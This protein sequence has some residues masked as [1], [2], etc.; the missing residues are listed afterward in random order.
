VFSA[1]DIVTE[2]NPGPVVHIYSRTAPVFDDS[3][4]QNNAAGP[5]TINPPV[6]IVF[7]SVGPTYVNGQLFGTIDGTSFF[8]QTPGGDTSD[9]FYETYFLYASFDGST[10]APVVYPDGTSID[11]LENQILIQISPSTVPNGFSGVVYPS[12]TFTTTGGS[13][14]PPYT[15]S[16]QNLPPGMDVTPGG[17]L[18]GTPT[19]SGNN[20]FT[21]ILTDSL[22]RTVEWNYTLTIQ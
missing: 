2:N 22:N 13:F 21:L 1:A 20:V 19:Q 15:W 17:T 10:N 14:S 7:N 12:V 3:L 11:G 6:T 4:V 5:G 9:A 16:A 8:T 18:E